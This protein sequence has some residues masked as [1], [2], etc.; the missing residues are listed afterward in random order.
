MQG[1]DYV[2]SKY[3][4]LPS[5]FWWLNNKMSQFIANGA[6]IQ[7]VSTRVNGGNP[8]NGLS[9]RIYYYNRAKSIFKVI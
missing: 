3:V 2:A 4:F 7:Q 5:G 1:C 6:T 8:A 9:D